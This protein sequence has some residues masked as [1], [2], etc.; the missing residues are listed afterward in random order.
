MH[1]HIL[2]H[3]LYADGSQVYIFLYRADTDLSLKQLD[4]CLSDISGWMT[5]IDLGTMPIK[6]ISSLKIHPDNA[7]NLLYANLLFSMPI[8]NHSMTPSNTVRNLDVAF[9]SDFN[10]RKHVSLT[11]RCCFH[12]IRDLRSI[13]RHVSLSV[14][15]TMLQHSLL[16][17]LITATLFFRTSHIKI[18]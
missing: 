4:N 14:A 3:H 10:F 16:V 9:D 5:K 1:S 7:A 12:H 8:L 13:R 17:G 15:K 18:F 11:C 6:H 2:D